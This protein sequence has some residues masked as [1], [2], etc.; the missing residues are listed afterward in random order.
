MDRKESKEW[1]DMLSCY[2]SCKME[3]KK[4]ELTRKT[5][6]NRMGVIIRSGIGGIETLES[7]RGSY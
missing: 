3:W 7:A 5:D 4:Q 2:G 6:N 1:I